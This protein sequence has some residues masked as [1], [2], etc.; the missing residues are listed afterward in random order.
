MARSSASGPLVFAVGAEGG[1]DAKV[2]SSRSLLSERTAIP[3]R[4]PAVVRDRLRAVAAAHSSMS[5]AR[6]D[7]P[8]SES[9]GLSP[10][11][12]LGPLSQRRRDVRSSPRERPGWARLRALDSACDGPHGRRARAPAGGSHAAAT[13]AA[14]PRRGP[15]AR[16]AAERAR[17]Q[18]GR[19]R[20]AAQQARVRHRPRPAHHRHARGA[21]RLRRAVRRPDL[22]PDVQLRQVLPGH[23]RRR[24]VL[25][26]LPD[27]SAG[28]R[29]TLRRRVD[30][31]SARR[32]PVLR[33]EG[34]LLRGE[35]VLLAGG[36]LRPHLQADRELCDGECCAPEEECITARFPGQPARRLCFVKCP[37]GAQRCGLGGCCKRGYKCV[38]PSIG[39]CSR[40]D[41]GEQPCGRKCCRARQLVLRFPRRPLLQEADA[42]LRRLRR[43]GEVLPHG[44][45]GVHGRLRDDL[46][47]PRRGLRAGRRP[48]GHGAGRAEPQ[49]RLLPERS[50]GPLRARRGDV[51]PRRA[52]SPSAD[53]S[54]CRPSAAA[55]TA[56]GKTRSAAAAPP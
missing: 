27:L 33:A 11:G 53:G 31:M 25:H 4:V 39:K 50:H 38:D 52:T 6:P 5:A 41:V 22:Q 35:R 1:D 47:R 34:A 21:V 12:D 2:G 46:L 37:R 29:G 13:G 19:R 14:T 3:R 32:P 10:F 44:P 17:R 15:R 48:D 42:G 49:A 9:G 51:L 30:R 26:L 56:A 45:Q 16:R 43:H 28:R 7:V 36:D 54:S 8:D 24:L 55:A 23:R 18:G 40:C 20:A